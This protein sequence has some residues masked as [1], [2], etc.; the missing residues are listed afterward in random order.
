M[1]RLRGHTRIDTQQDM[2]DEYWYQVWG[3]PARPGNRPDLSVILPELLV[4]EYP[5]PD[6]AEWLRGTHSVTAVVS[7]QDDADLASKGLRL[8]ELERAYDAH[9]LRFHR[10]PVPDCDSDVLMARLDQ[11][12]HLLRDLLGDG[13]RV[14]LHCNAGMNRAPTVAI[15]YLHAAH[16]LPL[17]AAR[18]F[19]KARRHCVPYM[20]VL[21]AHYVARE[22]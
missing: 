9:G 18:E 13:G 15:A 12:V 5:T 19:V 10:V 22:T 14:Y 17:S 2:A 16:G 6:D 3:P 4:G 8:R 20:R 1:E 11:I 21:E 7:L